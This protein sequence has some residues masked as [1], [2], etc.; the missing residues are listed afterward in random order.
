MVFLRFM[1]NSIQLNDNVIMPHIPGICQ[2]FTCSDMHSPVRPYI[3]C[4][5]WNETKEHDY[6][7]IFCHVSGRQKSYWS[8]IPV[9]KPRIHPASQCLGSNRGAGDRGAREA[10]A[11]WGGGIVTVSYTWPIM[12]A[13]VSRLPLTPRLSPGKLLLSTWMLGCQRPLT[14][15]DRGSRWRDVL[16]CTYWLIPPLVTYPSP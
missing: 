10:P 5:M 3:R 6:C 1:M 16:T 9:V 12:D 8:H 4:I 15:L 13:Q 7:E 14:R 2:S 11:I